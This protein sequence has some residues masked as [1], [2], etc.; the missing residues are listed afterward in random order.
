[1]HSADA[2]GTLIPPFLAYPEPRPTTYDPLTGAPRGKSVEYSTKGWMNSNIF[3][4]FIERFDRHAGESPVVLRI[5]SVSSHINMDVFTTAREK[6]LEIYRLVPY[7]AYLMQPLDEGLLGLLN[8][9]R[10]GYCFTPY[11]RQWLYNGAPLVA[12]NDTLGI[13]RTYSRLK[14]PASS[15]G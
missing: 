10:L 4:T 15:R 12:F 14:P 8:F 13:R 2:E 7:V 11:Q 9:V 1:M 5:D 3:L 6:G